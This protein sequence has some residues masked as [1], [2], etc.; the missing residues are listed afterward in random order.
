[1]CSNWNTAIATLIWDCFYSELKGAEETLQKAMNLWKPRYYYYWA[2]KIVNYL[3]HENRQPNKQFLRFFFILSIFLSHSCSYF[4]SVS[5][6]LFL[7]RFIEFHDLKFLIGISF[8]RDYYRKRFLFCFSH[9]K[10]LVI[11]TGFKWLQVHFKWNDSY[12]QQSNNIRKYHK[13]F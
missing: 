5:R 2:I 7:F 8:I 13:N 1:M 12:V 4:L 6:S 11:I 10:M 3:W 9:C